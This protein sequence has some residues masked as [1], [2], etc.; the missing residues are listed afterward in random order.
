MGGFSYADV[1]DSAKGWAGTI[2][3]NAKLWEQFTTF[4][5]RQAR[6]YHPGRSRTVLLLKWASLTRV[7][8]LG[9]CS[10]LTAWHAVPVC[11]GIHAL[12]YSPRKA[13]SCHAGEMLR[14]LRIAGQPL[15][16]W[17]YAMVSAD[18]QAELG[19]HGVPCRP[20]TFSL[21]ICNGCQLMALLGWVPG[22]AA[23]GTNGTAGSPFLPDKRQ[24]RFIHNQSGRFESRWTQVH[25]QKDSPAVML[26]VR[27]CARWCVWVLQRQKVP[28][29]S[30][31]LLRR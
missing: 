3:C 28:R 30:Q 14:A 16:T 19:A 9:T 27:C 5:N 22:T 25:I 26:K 6:A 1:L 20:D 24:P 11:G 10:R 8:T 15:L 13:F 29:S 12:H 4:Y 18:A 23:S 21:G 17:A 7:I 2:R 31:I